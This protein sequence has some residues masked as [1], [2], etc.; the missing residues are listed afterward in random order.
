MC[1]AR[2]GAV[3][4]MLTKLQGKAREHLIRAYAPK[5]KGVLRSALRKFAMFVQSIP[6][7]QLFLPSKVSGDRAAA[8]H[9]EWTLIL[10]VEWLL[11]HVSPKT[12]K[13]VSSSTVSG[14]LSLLKGYFL[15]SYDF[16]IP[17][18]SPRLSRLVALIRSEDL[19]A[20]SRSKRHGFRRRHLRKLWKL[21]GTRCGGSQHATTML[22]ALATAWH[23]LARGG[24]LCS[25]AQRAGPMRSDVEYKVLSTGERY[26]IIWLRPLKTKGVAPKVPQYVQEAGGGGADVYMLLRR[27]EAADP[28]SSAARATTP[29]FR[30][31]AKRGGGFRSI[32]VA[33]LRKYTRDCAAALGYLIRKQWGAH[34]GRIGGATDLAS[35]GKASELLLKAKGRWAS[36]I[37]RIYARMTRR[38]QLAA[39]RLM[40]KARGRDLEEIHPS[41]TQGI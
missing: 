22:A 25:T 18:P 34:S 8:A 38:C 14:Y 37:G 28:V 29:L 12:G 4:D 26:A 16:E 3:E 39:S 20:G 9:N 36:D 33:H 24:E 21:G 5:S 6:S 27:M 2:A 30:T 40:H 17:N 11:E 35:T 10:F 41:F 15:F 1:V 7:R 19:T 23:V 32:T 31:R 13:P